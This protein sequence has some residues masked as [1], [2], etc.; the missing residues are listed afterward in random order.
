MLHCDA[1]PVFV[2]YR[3]QRLVVAPFQATRA[4]GAIGLDDT[5]NL[6]PASPVTMNPAK[7]PKQN[8]PADNIIYHSFKLF[9]AQSY[10]LPKA[11]AMDKRKQV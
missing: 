8:H 2:A 4:S 5:R 1:F 10:A 3:L 9:A 6:V 7:H 11:R